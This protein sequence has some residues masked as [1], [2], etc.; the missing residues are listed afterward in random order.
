MADVNN[1]VVYK[2][3]WAATVQDRLTEPTKWKDIM[4][5]DYR[6]NQV[7]NNPYITDPTVQTY[8]RGS[9]YTNQALVETSESITIN[10]TVILPQFIDRADLGQSGYAR[11]MD[12]ADQQGILLN[13]K[14]ENAI[15]ANYSQLTSFGNDAL[16]GAAGSITVSATNI[17]DIVRTVK[18]KILE[19]SGGALLDR[20]GAFFVWRPADFN[21][22]EQFCQA[23]GFMMADRSLQTGIGSGYRG[24]DAMGFTHYTSNQLTAQHVI[25]GVKKLWHLGIYTGTYGQT[26]F[27]EDPLERSG[28]GVVARIDYQTKAWNKPKPVLFNVLVV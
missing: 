15:F 5:V 10:Q 3:D 9:S 25:A 12:I 20:N 11:Q 6:E 26:V 7:L 8:T 23:N 17:D 27:T 22:L 19:A 4:R 24:F 21:L 13:E 14:L 16:G 2:Q 1:T 18:Q 28:V